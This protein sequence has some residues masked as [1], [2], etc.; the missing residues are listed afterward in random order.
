MLQQTQVNRVELYYKKWLHK[1]P[2]IR[3]LSKASKADVLKLWSG[4][5]YNNRALRLHSLSRTIDSEFKGRI[6]HDPELLQKL[7]GIGKYTAHAIACFAFGADVPLV[8][9]NIRRIVSRMTTHVRSEGELVADTKAWETASILLPK[10]NIYH[11]NQA[12]MDIGALVCTAKNP[13]CSNCPLSLNCLSS[14]SPRLYEKERKKKTK[15][16]SY[17]GIP[18]RIIRGKILRLLHSRKYSTG[19]MLEVLRTNRIDLS[20]RNLME[21]LDRMTDDGLVR[22]NTRGKTKSVAVAA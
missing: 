15:E 11:W 12:L 9:I 21:I 2:T 20:R 19:E 17:H 6:P 5:G 18:R 10:K 1:Y 8:D 13:S 4:L 14:Y 22:V 7:P 3:S 16:P